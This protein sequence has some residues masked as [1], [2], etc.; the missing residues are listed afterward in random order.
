MHI[1]PV[2]QI[3]VAQPVDLDNPFETFKICKDLEMV[4]RSKQGLGLSAVQVG[5]PLKLFVFQEAGNYNYFANCEYKPVGE[6]QV[7]T[8]EGCLS[9]PNR[10]FR[11]KR[12]AEVEVTGQK[13]VLDDQKVPRFCAFSESMQTYVTGAKGN[14]FQHEIDHH[15]EILISDIGEEMFLYPPR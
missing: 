5:V 11:V 12:W 10:F 4:C 15:N 2:D 9:L 8:L 1:V 7:G 6:E 14:V 3:P 13:L